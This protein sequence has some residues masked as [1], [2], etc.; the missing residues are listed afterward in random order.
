MQILDLENL[1]IYTQILGLENITQIYEKFKA[2]A[3]ENEDLLTFYRRKTIEF[4][5]Q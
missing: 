4:M 5:Q 3:Q 2:E 1:L